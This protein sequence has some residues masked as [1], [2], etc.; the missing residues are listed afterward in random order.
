MKPRLI[1]ARHGNTFAPHETPVWVGARSDLPLV[2]SG[3]AQ[4][5]SLAQALKKASFQ[6]SVLATGPLQ[7]TRQMAQIAAQRLG[8]PSDQIRVDSRLKEIDYGA[9][10][11]KT[12]AETEQLWGREAVEAWTRNSLFP[13]GAGWQPS[14]AHIEEK[15]QEILKESV[16]ERAL[17][18]TSGGILRFFG[19][20]AVNT[21]DFPD[22][23]VG[24]G[25]V[26]VMEPEGKEFW[27]ILACNQLPEFLKPLDF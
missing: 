11:G 24:T 7:R 2:P 6:P 3:L 23:K 12:T 15:A 9:W 4:A 18:V 5:E 10:E 20:L 26:C 19:R 22:L 13:P 1:L 25:H 14:A 21:Q 16:A 8:F 27:R 17:Y